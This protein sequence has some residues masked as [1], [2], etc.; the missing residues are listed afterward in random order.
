MSR[1]AFKRGLARSC[2]SGTS[3]VGGLWISSTSLTGVC[4]GG[5]WACTLADWKKNYPRR[6]RIVALS[7]RTST[8]HLLLCLF[9]AGATCGRACAQKSLRVDKLFD[10]SHLVRVDIE[11]PA[12]DWDELRATTR[13][14]VGS[15]GRKPAPR[16]YRY[17]KGH[18][19]VDGV[20]IENVGIRKKGFI[21]SM[22]RARPSLK[23]KFA[24]YES[25]QP[26]VGFDRLT[27]NNYKQ[28]RSLLSQL[29]TFALFRASGAPAPRCN[30][31]RVSVN[32]QLLGVYANVE[33][34]K[35]PFLKHAFGDG[36]GWLY[37]GAVADFYKDSLPRFERKSKA[38][39]I[40]PIVAVTKTLHKA[41]LDLA[42][43]GTLVDVDAF[44][45][46]WAMESLVG[47]W[48]GYA[49]NQNNFFLY[50]K[51]D[52]SKLYF[53]PWGAD[54]AFTSRMPMPP[55]LIEPKSVHSQSILA[56]RLFRLPEIQARYRKVLQQLLTTVWNEDQLYARIDSVV[57]LA[58]DHLHASQRRDFR[59][60]TRVVRRFIKNRRRV[61]ERELRR[62]PV[63]LKGGPRQPFYTDP[64]GRV[65]GS[66]VTTWHE[67]EPSKPLTTGAVDLTLKL[68]GEFVKFSEIG[69]T[70]QRSTV[71]TIDGGPKPPA[72]V[73]TGK[74]A[75]DGQLLVIAISCEATDFQPGNGGSVT[76][77]GILFEGR[78]GWMGTKGI[79]LVGGTAKLESAAMQSGAEVR[80]TLE[81]E[82]AK[83]RGGETKFFRGK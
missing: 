21:G 71:P 40:G 68:G 15:V 9:V 42:H 31:A 80:G 53:I 44:L 27:L 20:R 19:T 38:T 70:A 73:F 6:G 74:R 2:A 24:E 56:N 52:N 10:P 54:A 65:S 39:K 17:Y 29:L 67:G 55:Y 77:Q 41:K 13:T 62:W 81:L 48:D 1:L 83:L 18:L 28:D 69:V 4:G 79:T 47:F 82:V 23:V 59:R 60:A 57:G 58:T 7:M 16:P 12:A 11:L 5:A 75:T 50:R 3:K 22:D 66:F 14:F 72:I 78:L 76:V 37:E 34:I 61:I 49:Q 25:Q 33:S 63:R 26:A 8:S 32:G 45:R 35:V 64:V 36:S 46:F 43:L 30:L 51:P